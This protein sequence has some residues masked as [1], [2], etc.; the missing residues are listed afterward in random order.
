MFWYALAFALST[1]TFLLAAGTVVIRFV[2]GVQF[3]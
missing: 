1:V 2:F 3:D